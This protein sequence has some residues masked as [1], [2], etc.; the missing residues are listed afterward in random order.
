[1]FSGAPTAIMCVDA[2]HRVIR[3]NRAAEVLFGCTAG[4]AVGGAADRF[5]SQRFLRV[6]DTHLEGA[7]GRL[8]AITAGVE[9]AG[10]IG[11]RRDGTEFALDAAIARVDAPGGPVCLIVVRDVT[12][13]KRHEDE[14]TEELRRAQVERR[15][16]EQAAR[17]S[18]LLAEASGMLTGSLDYETT[19]A[20]L[21]R[22][23]AGTLADWC[24]DR[25]GRGRWRDPSTGRRPLRSDARAGGARAPGASAPGGPAS[26]GACARAR[27]TPTPS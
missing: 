17:Q 13:Q 10:P 23:V 14:R 2:A 25:P 18:V 6:L 24:D 16:A 20:S 27:P 5:F 12:E 3:F 21:A 22:L 8:R 19:L 26:R 1:M 11:F 15:Q 9:A 4:D 7:R